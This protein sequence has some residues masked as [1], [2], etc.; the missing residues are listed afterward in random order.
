MLERYC[1]TRDQALREQLVERFLPLVERLAGVVASRLPNCVERD[2]LE[3]AGAIGLLEA[4]EG[5]DPARN[6]L[7]PTYASQRIRGAML[8][9]LRGQDEMPRLYRVRQRK[10]QDQRTQHY[11]RTG[12]RLSDVELEEDLGLSESQIRYVQACRGRENPV[13][14]SHKWYDT[15]SNRE[16]REGDLLKDSNQPD[17]SD[18]PERAEWIKHLVRH[19][20]LQERLL[21]V[22]Y[23]V[24]GM[25]LKEIGVVLGL[26]ESRCSQLRSNIIERL[27][28]QLT[29]GDRDVQVCGTGIDASADG[30]STRPGV[31]RRL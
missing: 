17:P 13:L 5:F 23:Y 24:E 21:I 16:V 6:I 27:R 31:A 28:A 18:S 22:L 1:C 29:G 20:G 2:D 12:E 10:M 4:L 9:Y 25:T 8:D 11:V 3:Q 26:S 19:L 7:F 15:D 30:A 14:L